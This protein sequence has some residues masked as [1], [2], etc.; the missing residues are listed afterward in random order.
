MAMHGRGSGVVGY[1]V[2]AA[3]DTQHHL[4]VAYEVT[5]EGL[6]RDQFASTAEQA[7]KAMGH[8]AL[9]A[10]ADRGCYKGEEILACDRRASRRWYLKPRR[11]PTP[12]RFALSSR[13]SPTMLTR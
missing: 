4:I 9:T 1:N 3:V 8:D 11:P 6:D 2:Q 7:R 10:L 5:K 13:T 12:R